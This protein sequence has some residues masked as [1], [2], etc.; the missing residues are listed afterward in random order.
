MS[1]SS[2]AAKLVLQQDDHDAGN[3]G[4]KVDLLF[5]AG[6]LEIS[7]FESKSKATLLEGTQETDQ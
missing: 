1:E 5:Y 7:I 6:E 4:R 3:H 2:K